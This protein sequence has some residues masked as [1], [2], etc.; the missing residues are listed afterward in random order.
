MFQDEICSVS[1]ESSSNSRSYF[2]QF[3]DQLLSQMDRPFSDKMDH[4][5]SDSGRRM[6]RSFSDRM[7]RPFS[8]SGRRRHILDLSDNIDNAP[9]ADDGNRPAFGVRVEDPLLDLKRDFPP[10]TGDQERK[11][12]E[13]RDTK[14][15]GN[16]GDIILS[17]IEP[18]DKDTSEETKQ[19]VVES[20]PELGGDNVI[21]IRG[22]PNDCDETVLM[23]LLGPY[24]K[25]LQCQR[26]SSSDDLS[27]TFLVR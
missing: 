6:D 27:A 13:R 12:S 10:L 17:S 20:G 25:I 16:I 22:F 3:S 4:P 23:E 8:D 19:N 1:S 24:G 9:D 7:E 26:S 2:G 18:D 14:S 15:L 5:F 21:A 11:S